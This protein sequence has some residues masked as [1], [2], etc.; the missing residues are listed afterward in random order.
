MKKKNTTVQSITEAFVQT[1]THKAHSVL[2]WE[3][4]A[5]DSRVL[6]AGEKRQT[7]S[8]HMVYFHLAP[9]K[10]SQTQQASGSNL[11]GWLFLKRA[12]RTGS[13]P[14]LTSLRHFILYP[15]LC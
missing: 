13:K 5:K 14:K 6:Q 2:R 12:K 7:P 8:T 11:S 15:A 10:L 9:G 4:E 3:V 1:Q